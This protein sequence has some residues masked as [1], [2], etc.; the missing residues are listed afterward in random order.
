MCGHQYE[1]MDALLDLHTYKQL[2]L[3]PWSHSST[4]PPHAAQLDRIV[5]ACLPTSLPSPAGPYP[6]PTLAEHSLSL[7]F[8]SRLGR[9]P[10][11]SLRQLDAPTPAHTRS[12]TT[13]GRT[14]AATITASAGT[15]FDYFR[16][17][18]GG[19][20]Y[21]ASGTFTDWAYGVKGVLSYG[22][23]LRPLSVQPGFFL[24][25]EEIASASEETLAGLMSLVQAVGAGDWREA[26]Q[27]HAA[28]DT[29]GGMGPLG[30]EAG[31]ECS[32]PQSLEVLF[33]PDLYPAETTWRLV[34]VRA[35]PCPSL[36]GRLAAQAHLPPWASGSCHLT[37]IV[38]LAMPQE[39]VLENQCALVY[40]SVYWCKDGWLRGSQRL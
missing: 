39:F 18:A 14:I 8:R 11:H 1:Q 19:E 10:T 9:W 2:V 34:H 6:K 12:R 15:A 4:P 30:A 5:R 17:D 7:R 31:A 29:G 25:P 13:Q 40:I 26:G 38:L 22:L 28:D 27:A 21:Y 37:Y 3:A 36:R 16:A 24:P 20:L 32:A 33:T 35:K 23:E